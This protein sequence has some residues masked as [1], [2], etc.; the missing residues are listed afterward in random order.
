MRMNRIRALVI[1]TSGLSLAGLGLGLSHWQWQ[2]GQTKQ[3]LTLERQAQA[4]KRLLP[5]VCLPGAAASLA[6]EAEL[7]GKAPGVS[8]RA[9]AECE[10]VSQRWGRRMQLQGHWVSGHTLFLDNR[11]MSGR[12]GFHVLTPLRLDDGRWLLVQ[13]G[14]VPRD[15]QQRD[16]LPQWHDTP[17]QVVVTG[18]LRPGAS[19]AYVLGPD[20]SGAIRQAVTPVQL[21]GEWRQDVVPAVLWQDN[22]EQAAQDG[23]ASVPP[24][25]RRWPEPRSDVAKHEGYAFQWLALSVAVLLL[26]LWHQVI[27][28]RRQRHHDSE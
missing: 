17:S 7:A 12:V 8:A 16:R 10:P 1:W 19:S 3:A 14:F 9:E 28:P 18:T 22:D 13:R 25:D 15:F 5:A 11:Q 21:A 26:L 23:G 2:K 4:A 24:L 20:G 27:Q 6:R